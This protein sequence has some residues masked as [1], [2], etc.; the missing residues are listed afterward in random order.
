MPRSASDLLFACFIRLIVD[1][2]VL[3]EFG[4][5]LRG[6]FCGF[7]TGCLTDSFLGGP[8]P[9][10]SPAVVTV[11]RSEAITVILKWRCLSTVDR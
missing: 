3:F 10:V 1:K 5:D 9:K 8:S 11:P 2:E 7:Q 4:E 6:D